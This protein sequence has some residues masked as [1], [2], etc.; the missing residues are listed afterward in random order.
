M[1]AH[2]RD[3]EKPPLAVV[4]GDGIAHERVGVFRQHGIGMK[5]EE[6]VAA[7]SPRAG[8]HLRRATAWGCD[9]RIRKLG[10][11]LARAIAAAAVRDDDLDAARA[12]RRQRPQSR[13]DVCGFVQRRDD[14]R[15]PRH[16]RIH[17]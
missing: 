7:C 6:H 13:L 1:R 12:Q 11:K 4:I 14:D 17:A 5:K 2:D 16:V 8:V 10:R 3:A 15:K 9:H